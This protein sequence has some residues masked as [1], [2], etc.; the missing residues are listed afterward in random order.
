MTNSCEFVFLGK[1]Q[2]NFLPSAS[3]FREIDAQILISESIAT[4]WYHQSSPTYAKFGHFGSISQYIPMNV[5]HLSFNLKLR[6]PTLLGSVNS[7]KA[8]PWWSMAIQPWDPAMMW[9]VVFVHGNRMGIVLCLYIDSQADWLFTKQIGFEA[10]KSF[11]YGSWVQDK[12]AT[13]WGHCSLEL[14]PIATLIEQWH[15]SEWRWMVILS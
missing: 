11:G 14:W 5:L 7:M 4:Q 9:S 6:N 1:N 3:Y 2:T 13:L 15:A 12:H 8:N 10:T